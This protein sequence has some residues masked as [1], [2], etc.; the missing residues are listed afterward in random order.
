VNVP[1][2][3]GTVEAVLADLRKTYATSATSG[4]GLVYA[5]AIGMITGLSGSHD[6]RSAEARMADVVTVCAAIRRFEDEEAM[7]S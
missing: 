3:N 4:D 1:W 7:P 5:A 2:V 6:H